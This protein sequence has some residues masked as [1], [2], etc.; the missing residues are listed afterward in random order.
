L[1]EKGA[2]DVVCAGRDFVADAISFLERRLVESAKGAA[3]TVEQGAGIYASLAD[4]GAFLRGSV[5]VRRILG[6]MRALMAVDYRSAPRLSEP[7][8]EEVAEDAFALFRFCLAPR[9]WRTPIP[10]RADIFRRLASGDLDAAARHAAAHLRAH[11]HIPPLSLVA[12]DPRHLAA[13]LAFP[14][15]L[16]S[17]DILA[18]SFVSTASSQ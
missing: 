10:T 6:M 5:D 17:R 8:F 7:P 9:H 1:D 16:K 14:V 12:G 3:R 18:R 15:S 11:G 13:A 4:I 2:T